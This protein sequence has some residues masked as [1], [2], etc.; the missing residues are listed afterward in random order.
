MADGPGHL[1]YGPWA[2][3][4]R[5]GN[6]G[7]GNVPQRD[8]GLLTATRRARSS[9]FLH[10]PRSGR[11]KARRRIREPAQMQQSRGAFVPPCQICHKRRDLIPASWRQPYLTATKILA[12]WRR[13]SSAPPAVCLLR[14]RASGRADFRRD[15]CGRGAALA[16]RPL[17][18]PILTQTCCCCSGS[19]WHAGIAAA[20]PSIMSAYPLTH[21]ALGTRPPSARPSAALLFAARHGWDQTSALLPAAPRRCRRSSSSPPKGRGRRAV[22]RWFRPCA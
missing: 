10:P 16:G 14:C 6:S 22:S 12:T 4:W 1:Y 19:R 15:V 17:P 7:C 3:P 18:A 21:R 9:H 11:V 8:A 5:P 13:S 20:D 2:V